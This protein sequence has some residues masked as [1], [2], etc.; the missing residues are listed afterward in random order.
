MVPPTV[1][2]TNNYNLRNRLNISQPSYRLSTYQQSY[3]PSTIKLWNTLDLNLRQLPTLPSF[4][5]KLQQKYFQPKTVPSYFSF[6]DR[7]LS[8]LHARLRNKCSSLNSD[9]FKSKL[10]PSASCSCGY[11]NECSEHFLLYCN[12]FNLLRN[13]MIIE[14]NMLDMGGLPVNTDIL[15]FGN[16]DLSVEINTFIFSCV[17]KYIKD[18]RRFSWTNKSTCITLLT[19]VNIVYFY[20]YVYSFLGR[21]WGIDWLTCQK[22]DE[23]YMC[24]SVQ[25]VLTYARSPRI[26]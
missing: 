7:Y 15:L 14:L 25:I 16:D 6:G 21:A 18:T 26:N 8:V 19:I 2:D 5:S 10:V 12:K 20:M 4:K 9:L 17:Q 1:A 13:N 23:I 24:Y 3:F 22:V 11:K